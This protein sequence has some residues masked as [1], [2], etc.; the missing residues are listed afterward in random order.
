MPNTMT[1]ITNTVVSSTVSSV[2]LSSIPQTYTDLKLVYSLRADSASNYSDVGLTFTGA[3]YSSGKI[4]YVINGTTVGTYSP[5]GPGYFISGTAGN[6]TAN[7]FSNGEVYIPNYTSTGNKSIAA[8]AVGETNGTNTIATISAGLYTSSTGITA[9]TITPS[10]G[11]VV[12]GST[13]YLYGIK[14]S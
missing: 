13:F 11:N 8:E 12:A 7:T 3:T 14:N 1:L 2:T 5:G 9:I 6:N 10:G 4:L